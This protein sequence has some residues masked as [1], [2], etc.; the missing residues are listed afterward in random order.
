MLSCCKHNQAGNSSLLMI[1]DEVKGKSFLWNRG[2]W[3]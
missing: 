1:I 2:C 3:C